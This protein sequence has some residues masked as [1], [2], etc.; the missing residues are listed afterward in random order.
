M[1]SLKI[2]SL[3]VLVI[4][5]SSG[6]DSQPKLSA[7]AIDQKVQEATQ[8]RSAKDFLLDAE[9][10]L[11]TIQDSTFLAEWVK[12]NFI[13]QDTTALA[14]EL[15][16]QW[17]ELATS[18]AK[19]SRKYKGESPNEQR[20]LDQ[21]FLGLTVPGPSQPEKN[22][23]LSKLKAELESMYGSG[24]VCDK[25]NNC[26]N[27]QQ[28]SEIIE[29]SREPKK[30]LKAW[31]DWRSVSV[32]MKEKFARTVDLGNIGAQEV[33]FKDLAALWKSKYDMGPDEFAKNLETIWGEVQPLYEQLHCYVRG[34]LNTKYG[35]DIVKKTGPIPAHLLGNMWAQSWSNIYDLM[36][37]GQG[38]SL[39]LTTLLEKAKY[40]PKKMVKTAENFFV[41]LGMPK[42]PETF[43]QRSLFEKPQDR[44]VVCHASAWHMDRKDDVRIKMC[45]KVDDDNFRTIHHEL[46]HIYYYLAYMNKPLP[47]QNSA[48]D[49]FHEAMGDTLELSMSPSYLKALKLLD[50][51]TPQTGEIPYLM[52]MALGKIAFLPFGL[53][54]DQWRWQVFSGELTQKDYN[55]GWWKLR[56]KY[57]GVAAPVKRGGNDFD[58]GSKYHIPAYTPYSR[59]FLAHI[60]QFQFHK[61]LCSLAGHKG[62]LHECSIFNSKAAGKKMWE[63]MTL[64]S[65]KPWPEAL[66]VLT[67][68]GSLSAEPL[69]E[70]FAPLEKW[71]RDKNKGQQCGW[72]PNKSSK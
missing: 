19:K 56:E 60:L 45:I 46:G 63:M 3:F 32:P 39:N 70:Y 30:L 11:S 14:S 12:S 27:L 48:N 22:E 54:V 61:A 21:F 38:E 34:Q 35:S 67:G 10:R 7:E 62:P 33:G 55:S 50:K 47:F 72:E 44:E 59:Y 53:M 25:A 65:S 23:E 9:N 64:G 18:I 49:G 69:R 68:N 42:L 2:L 41:S 66:A 24:K 20:K 5:C 8:H 15:G 36:E 51:N 1:K 52:K 13:T 71:L 28:L 6:E 29:K 16:A 57:Q 31:T 58:P 40:D 17:T 4:A 37:I 26:Q 43:Y